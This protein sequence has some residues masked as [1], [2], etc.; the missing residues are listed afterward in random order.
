MTGTASQETVVVSFIAERTGS[1]R[2]GEVIHIEH[3]DSE[4]TRGTLH[5]MARARSYRH[6]DIMHEIVEAAKECTETAGDAV[7][8]RV[9][10]N[11]GVVI[12]PA[13]RGASPRAASK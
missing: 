10:E 1:E 3:P 11:G 4:S 6:P 7:N 8:V 2:T 12:T 13:A 9:L 5:A